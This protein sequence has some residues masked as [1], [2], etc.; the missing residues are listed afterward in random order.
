[1]FVCAIGNVTLHTQIPLLFFLDFKF[2]PQFTYNIFVPTLRGELLVN[3]FRF[4]R[5]KES[6]LGILS[7]LCEQ[8]SKP[9]PGIIG[10]ICHTESFFSKCAQCPFGEF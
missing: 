6:G 2:I 3:L 4:G 1:M 5:Q 9:T 7:A 8:D 10:Y